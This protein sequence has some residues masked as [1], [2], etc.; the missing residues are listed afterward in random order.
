MD[1]VQPACKVI[2]VRLG[3]LKHVVKPERVSAFCFA[4]FAVRLLQ[5]DSFHTA[6]SHH[7]LKMSSGTEEQKQRYAIQCRHCRHGC[8]IRAVLQRCC[9]APCQDRTVHERRLCVHNVLRPSLSG[10][11]VNARRIHSGGIAATSLFVKIA[12]V[13]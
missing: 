12:F 10:T 5:Q 8:S 11:C 4:F 2:D 7:K 9:G 1:A 13:R 6:C 3:L